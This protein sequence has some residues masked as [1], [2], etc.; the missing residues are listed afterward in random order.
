MNT[1]DMRPETPSR[2]LEDYQITP[3]KRV[4]TPQAELQVFLPPVGEQF[5]WE[6]LFGGK[7]RVEVEIGFGKGRFLVASAEANPEVHYLGC[8]YARKY[9]LWTLKRFMR[10][11]CRN[12]RMIH[13]DAREL[14]GRAMPEASVD[15]FHIYFSDP[16]PKKRH[17][18]RRLF[19]REFLDMLARVL[20]PG[21]AVHGATDFLEYGEEILAL[22]NEHPDF[23]V[24]VDR[25]RSDGT[26]FTNFE[27]KYLLE[28]RSFRDWVARR[29]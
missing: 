1:P 4:L 10:R 18:R 28:G 13:A 3:P 15:A 6:E 8:E 14:V 12:V 7:G 21:G 20:K 19:Q 5:C 11:T 25:L 16:W 2:S 23:V 29:K 22:F 27:A 9:F 24:E 26:G 17:H